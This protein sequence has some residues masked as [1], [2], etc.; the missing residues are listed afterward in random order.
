MRYV[1]ILQLNEG[2]EVKHS[3]FIHGINIYQTSVKLD[4]ELLALI[5]WARTPGFHPGNRSSILRVITS[6]L[7]MLL[8][9]NLV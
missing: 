7:L 4:L 9:T 5:A 1:I 2:E 6:S 8:L 3:S